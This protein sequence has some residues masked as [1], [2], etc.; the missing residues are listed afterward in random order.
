MALAKS[1]APSAAIAEVGIPVDADGFTTA[2]FE[3]ALCRDFPGLNIA[4]ARLVQRIK[5]ASSKLR[6]ELDSDYPG[7]PA[8]LMIKGGYEPHSG[9]LTIMHFNEMHAYRDLLPTVEVN[10]PRCFFAGAQDARAAVVLEDLDLHGAHFLSLQKPLGF[11]CAARFLDGLARFHARWW[12][13]PDLATRFGWAEESSSMQ[14]SFYFDIL[15]DPAQFAEYAAAP[16]GTAMPRVLRDA[17]RVARAHNVLTGLHTAMPQTM[18]HGDAHL[19]N[20]YLD[21]DGTPGFLDW[22]PRR[23]PWALD[24]TYF[25]IAALDIVDRRRWE[26]A[27]LQHYLGRLA[28]YGVEPP[29]FDAACDAYRRD[30]VW[31]LLI[32]MLN[33]TQFQTES[34]NTAAATRFAM[35]MIDHDTFARLGV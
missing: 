9:G 21:A 11:D 29:S 1:D 15:R 13:A 25:I 27:R 35:A 32:W 33:G 16:R 20:V 5:G 6:F 26:T 3:A 31:G 28:A 17:E 2:W 19:G 30:V 23:G 24:V 8:R 22:Q 7:L 4:S 10:A 34:N 18:L 14:T 12:S